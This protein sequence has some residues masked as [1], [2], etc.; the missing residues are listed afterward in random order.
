VVDDRAMPVLRTEQHDLGIVTD[1]DRVPCRASGALRHDLD[2][3]RAA[4]AILAML[5]GLYFEWLQ[6]P[7]TLRSTLPRVV[8]YLD[9][10][11]RR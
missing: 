6:S 11:L 10:M 3:Q 4:D 1:L 9:L 8:D 2:A 5:Y 7:T